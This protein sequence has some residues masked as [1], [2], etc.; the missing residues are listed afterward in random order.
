MPIGFLITA[1]VWA[2][3]ALVALAPPIPPSTRPWS[4]AFIFGTTPNEL[5]FF[6][7]YVL[8]W[9]AVST[10][11][12]RGLANPTGVIGLVVTVLAFAALL[13]IAR[14]GLATRTQLAAA[15]DSALGS[16][17]EMPRRHPWWRILA[18]PLS[19]HGRRVRREANIRYGDAGRRNLLDVYHHR[20]RRG[21][22]VLV[23]FHGGG[24]RSGHKNREAKPLIHRLARA[25][26]VC[27]DANYRLAPTARFPDF[28]VDAKLA[29]AWARRNA[30][31]FGGDPTSIFVA[32]SSAGAHLASIAALTPNVSMFQPGFVDVDTSVVGAIC[33]YG[34]YGSPDSESGVPATPHAYLNA[35]APPM[36]IAHGDNDTI[37]LVGDARTFAGA[38]GGVSSNP[39]LYAELPGAQHGFDVF[40]SA[41]FEAV[42]D[43][44]EIFTSH[45]RGR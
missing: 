22:P 32:G 5:P 41:R 35:D 43:A 42:V 21:G 26:W 17:S 2:A 23:Y 24:Y 13:V 6:A 16:G 7:M 44:V 12:G 19:F 31:R 10:A 20:T 14:R 1:V 36:F 33:L 45:A 25:G 4:W 29:I 38:L 40:R 8:G 30:A 11:S 15:L 18:A 9:S 37:V 28:L 27:I 39:V 34:F 3:L